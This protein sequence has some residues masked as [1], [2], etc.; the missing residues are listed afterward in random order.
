MDNPINIRSGHTHQ[1]D[2]HRSRI[3]SRRRS[4]AATSAL[5]GKA[6][7]T[8]DAHKNAYRGPEGFKQFSALNLKG[9][10]KETVSE[11]GNKPDTAPETVLRVTSSITQ[12]HRMAVDAHDEAEGDNTRS[13]VHLDSV[14]KNSAISVYKKVHDYGR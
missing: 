4:D 7:H 6:G 13:V 8:G 1:N 10:V 12:K 14:R 5:A 2:S 11:G 9:F 3:S